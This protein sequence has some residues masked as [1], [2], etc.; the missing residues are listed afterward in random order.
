MTSPV[1]DVVL[2]LSLTVTSV[3]FLNQLKIDTKHQQKSEQVCFGQREDH[4]LFSLILSALL[5]PGKYDNLLFHPNLFSR[6]VNPNPPLHTLLLPKTLTGAPLM[7]FFSK[8]C[9][10]TSRGRMAF[11]TKYPNCTYNF[12]RTRPVARF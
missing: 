6:G 7:V 3:C 10:A 12:G 9:Y 8:L 4:G 5:L 2:K 11:K 1:T